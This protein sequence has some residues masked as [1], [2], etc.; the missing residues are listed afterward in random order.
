MIV[1]YTPYFDLSHR[2]R[3]SLTLEQKV[4]G[5]GF[6]RFLEQCHMEVAG[7]PLVV[8]VF[9]NTIYVANHADKCRNLKVDV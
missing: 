5:L 6:S 9:Y 1:E 8:G 3:I 4:W 7:E 2:N